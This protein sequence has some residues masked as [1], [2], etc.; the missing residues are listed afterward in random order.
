MRFVLVLLALIAAGRF[1]AAYGQEVLQG[2]FWKQQALVDIIPAWEQHVFNDSTGGFHA[3]LKHD[4]TPY[5]HDRQY[6]G[7][8]S[9][10]LFSFSAAYLLSGDQ[11]YLAV[12]DSTF[13]YMVRHGWDTAHSGWYEEI[14]PKGQVTKATKD[15]F[16]QTYAIAGL[17]LYYATTRN[18]EAKAYLDTTYQRL[19]TKAWDKPNKGYYNSLKQ[20]WRVA[21]PQ[22]NFSPQLAPA[23][24]FLT[25]LYPITRNAKYRNHFQTL[26]T[27]AWNQMRH[28]QQPWIMESFTRDWQLIEGQNANMN[29][30]HNAEVVWLMLR[31]YHL[32]G[33]PGYRQKA[34]RLNQPLTQRAYDS[35]SGAWYHQIPVDKAHPK[36]KT[37]SWWVQAYGNM[38]QLY[39]YRITKDEQYLK[40]FQAG[41][42]FWNRAFLDEQYGGTVL[43]ADLAGNTQ[44]GAKAVRTKTAYHAMEHALLNYLY[45][46]CWVQEQPARLHYCL[47]NTAKGDQFRP[48]F[49]ADPEVRIKQ[50]TINGEP[51]KHFDADEQVITLPEG[52][53]LRLKVTLQ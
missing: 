40:R 37:A 24:G 43:K 29:V 2:D 12:A 9:R 20:D 10:Q 31:L 5:K 39:L 35:A 17:T 49:L 53:Q 47:T 52:K 19:R 50:V 48:V 13:R 3:Y 30:G 38:T 32:T 36:A 45:L 6:P 7:M 41:S 25:Y 26:L 51:W 46:K 14:G 1:P 22:K 27:M 33:E 28:P 8:L 42:R 34:L 15:L 18:P 11:H 44:K 23:S 4:W 21:D 16:M